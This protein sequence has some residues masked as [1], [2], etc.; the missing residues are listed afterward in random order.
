L[1]HRV[2]EHVANFQSAWGLVFQ[3]RKEREERIPM[4]RKTNY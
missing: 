3:V 2:G 1:W 4:N